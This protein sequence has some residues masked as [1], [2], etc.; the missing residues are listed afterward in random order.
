MPK[1]V[2]ERSTL[3]ARC[4]MEVSPVA[5]ARRRTRVALMPTADLVLEA[6]RTLRAGAGMAAR[7]ATRVTA[8]ARPEAD[9]TAPFAMRVGVIAALSAASMA[10]PALALQTP[11]ATCPD[12]TAGQPLSLTQLWERAQGVEPG[13]DARLETEAAQA[14]ARGAVTREWFPTFAL[15]AVGSQ[16]Q[17]LSPGE[18]RVLGVGPRGEL[19]LVGAWTLLD[20]SRRWRTNEAQRRHIEARFAGDAF[21][22]QHRGEVTRAYLEAAR[23]RSVWILLNEQREELEG[24]AALVKQRITAGVEPYWEGS[25]LDQARARSDG[26]L[27]AARQELEVAQAELA[28]LAG[29]CVQP[30]LPGTES[31]GLADRLP[32]GFPAKLE[33]E[34]GEGNPEVLRL[35]EEAR[36]QEAFAGSVGAQDRLQLQLL[37]IAGPNYSRAFDD[38]RV[39]QEY[40]VGVSGSWRPDIFGAR[41]QQAAAEGRRARALRAQATSH[42]QRVQ[43][44]VAGLTE[45]WAHAH[46]REVQLSRELEATRQRDQIARLRWQE[47]VG[48]W[49]Q[50]LEARERLDELRVEAAG[51]RQEMGLVLLEYA[52][53]TGRL[54]RLPGW[55]EGE[56]EQ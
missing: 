3:L 7:V 17:R 5:A 37:G 10:T 44:Q 13:Y 14:A 19:R 8:H 27:T 38:G 40:L 48:G 42:Q 2:V 56:V 26:R 53:W 29:V 30:R 46:A 28:G 55:L 24:L 32:D 45:Y 11:L 49:S 35:Q 25:L 34:A 41:R 15:E 4:V 9:A 52:E 43:R 39:E 20:S 1:P 22:D 31:G 33:E 6:A 18:E 21:S 36:A 23:A 16:G 50:V 51:L 54:D 12:G 47:G